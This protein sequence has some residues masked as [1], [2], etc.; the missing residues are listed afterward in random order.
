MKGDVLRGVLSAATPGWTTTCLLD[1]LAPLLPQG[2]TVDW[3]S[4]DDT[5]LHL[6]LVDPRT[7]GRS[8]PETT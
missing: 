8:C 6:R 2:F 7:P 5:S 4:L 1:C 3:F